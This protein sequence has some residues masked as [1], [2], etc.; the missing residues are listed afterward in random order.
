MQNSP[1]LK[2]GTL[3][4]LSPEHAAFPVR[5]TAHT[6]IQ[7]LLSCVYSF[8]GRVCGRFLSVSDA[9]SAAAASSMRRFHLLPW[10]IYEP[11]VVDQKEKDTVCI[12]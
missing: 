6:C 2:V 11:E 1:F 3:L 12:L 8:Q 7:L 5:L 10:N 4:L 9:L